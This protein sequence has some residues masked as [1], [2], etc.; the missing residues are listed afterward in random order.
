[1]HHSVLTLIFAHLFSSTF[2][3]LSV[4]TELFHSCGQRNLKR[5]KSHCS[6]FLLCSWCVICLREEGVVLSCR[7]P[8]QSFVLDSP[9][10]ACI[11]KRHWVGFFGCHSRCLTCLSCVT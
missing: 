2:P 1:M 3:L 5:E 9:M 11:L 10:V 7:L 4:S 6:I 8:P